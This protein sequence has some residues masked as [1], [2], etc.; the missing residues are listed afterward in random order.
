G[1]NNLNHQVI[2]LAEIVV[3]TVPGSRLE[4]LAQ[5]GADQRT[6]KTDFSKFAR[7]IPGFECKWNPPTG[8][9]ELYAAFKTVGLVR[10][11]FVDKRFTRLKWLRH[12]LDSG[13][14]DANLRWQNGHGGANQ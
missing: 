5:P 1:A 7:L 10:D 6:Y 11:T 3:R 14:L 2:E 8:A 13:Q 9:Q 4:V 12:L